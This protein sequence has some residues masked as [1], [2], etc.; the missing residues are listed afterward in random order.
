MIRPYVTLLLTLLAVASAKAQHAI[1]IEHLTEVTVS[2]DTRAVTHHRETVT[3]LDEQGADKA[4]FLCRCSKQERLTSFRGEAVDDQGHRLRKFRQSDLQRTEYSNYL[5]IDDYQQYLDYTPPSYPITI[6]YEWSME[7]HNTLIE[8]PPFCPQDDYEV[9]LRHAVYRLTVPADITVGHALQ[10]ISAEALTIADKDG[11]RSISLELSNLPALHNEPYARP[12]RERLPQ[13]YFAPRLFTYYDTKGSLA[14][15]NDY[16]R[17]EYSLLQGRDILPETLCTKLH[18]LTDT[19]PTA[20]RKVE[21]L[22]HYLGQHTRYVAILL[23]IGGQQPAPAT[24][25]VRSG[26]GDCK[27]LSNLM[28]AMLRE[29][30]ISS[31]YTVISTRNRRLLPHFASAGQ[32]NHVILQVPLP[33]DTLWLECTNPQLPFGYIHEDIAGHDAIAIDEAG[34]HLVTLPAYADTLNRQLSRISITVKP[35]GNADINIRQVSEN[36]QYEAL[37]PMLRMEPKEQQRTLSQLVRAPQANISRINVRQT[38][39][40]AR[41]TLEADISSQGY[42]TRAGQRLFLPLCPIHQGYNIS[43]T[44]HKRTEPLC[45]DMGYQDEDRIDITL[46]E[47]YSLE[48]RPKNISIEK[49]FGSFLFQTKVAEG[50]LKVRYRVLL[51]AGNYPATDYADFEAFIKA[52]SR[53]YAQRAVCVSGQL[54]K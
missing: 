28:R 7:L 23:G 43:S 4:L 27:G 50:R 29:V 22:Y 10:N 48:A 35:E 17:W 49:P 1:I 6:T 34:G 44:G 5:A 42:A 19:L 25:V 54:T 8:Y 13:A 51:R 41:L 38:D 46:P 15:W 21:A 52:I 45:I 30:G 14:S 47:G 20:R 9:S 16:G 26:F 33:A 32:T 24:D 11:S 40:T 39:A 3:I 18:Q 12:L 36:R 37:A 31:R 2:S 53:S